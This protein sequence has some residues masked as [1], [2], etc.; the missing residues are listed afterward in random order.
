M[1]V[2]I[3]NRIENLKGKPT[4][5]KKLTKEKIYSKYYQGES[6]IVFL[7]FKIK[8]FHLDSNKTLNR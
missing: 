1:A 6:Q 7:E 3:N 5:K 4:F 2:G 8:D